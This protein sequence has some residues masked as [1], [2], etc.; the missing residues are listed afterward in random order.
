MNIDFFTISFFPVT[1][2][3]FLFVFLWKNSNMEKELKV[4]FYRLGV[5]ILVELVLYDL[6]LILPDIP[7]AKE[8]LTLTTALG[9]SLR[10]V[11]LYLLIG[12][13]IR[14]DN[15]K[16]IRIPLIIPAVICA[17]TSF[18]AFFTDI[19]YSYDDMKVFHRGFLGWTPHIIMAFYLIAM[20][21]FSFTHKDKS[22]RFESALI[23][24]ISLIII[25]A[26]FAESLF[27]NVVVLRIAITAVLIFYYMFFQSELYKDK[28][29]EEQK[30]R[31]KAEESFSMQIVKTLAETVEA[32]D[33]YTKGHSYRVAEYSR[34]IAKRLGKDDDFLRRVYYMGMLHDVGKIGISDAIINKTERLTDE[35]YQIVKSH[36]VIGDEVLRHV[37]VMPDLYYGSRWHHE[38]YDGKGYPDGLKGEEIPLEVRIIAVADLY[39]AMTSERSYRTALPIKEARA[40]I[41][42][43]KGTQL[44]PE[45]ADVML[46][47]IDEAN[48]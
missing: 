43:S 40:E 35:E 2:I 6:E 31:I 28:I 11:M 33:H 26:V 3:L 14:R 36:T 39:D 34:E 19:V 10:P 46:K 41:E 29:I 9:Y 7:C 38:R 12:I 44:D 27:E 18:S 17:L 16:S 24:G 45:I 8:W 30:Q 22:N 32:K 21:F 1:G 48:T 37:T 47:M 4:L 13:I 25:V 23:I 42:R 15:R 5:L 20:I